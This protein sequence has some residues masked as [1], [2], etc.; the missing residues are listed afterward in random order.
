MSASIA[1]REAIDPE[2]AEPAESAFVT[3]AVRI[4]AIVGDQRLL[5]QTRCVDHVLD[6]LKLATHGAVRVELTEFLSS[7]RK[8]TAVEGDRMRQ[9][10]GVT[11]MADEVETAYLSSVAF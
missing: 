6:L 3:E 4:R 11:V 1:A 9:L 8:Q 10:L 7:I 2:P 5:S